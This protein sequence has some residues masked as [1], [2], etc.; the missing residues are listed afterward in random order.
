MKNTLRMLLFTFSLLIVCEILSP[1]EGTL[2]SSND[3]WCQETEANSKTAFVKEDVTKSSLIDEL[4]AKYNRVA[5]SEQILY[6]PVKVQYFNCNNLLNPDCIAYKFG[7]PSIEDVQDEI[8]DTNLNFEYAGYNVRLYL[9]DYVGYVNNDLALNYDDSAKDLEI[10][11]DYASDGVINVFYMK[12][13]DV[14]QH[15]YLP[16]S[17]LDLI[18]L[19]RDFFYYGWSLTHEIGHWFGLHHTFSTEQGVENVTRDSNDP[20]YNCETTGDLL[21]DTP[22]ALNLNF[23]GSAVVNADC[24][25][26]ITA[27]TCNS[28]TY[29]GNPMD[30]CNT[31]IS[32]QMSPVTYLNVMNYGSRNCSQSI[33]QD[34]VDRMWSFIPTRLANDVDL[35]N[36]PP[37][38]YCP[39]ALSL[40]NDNITVGQRIETSGQLQSTQIINTT[41]ATLYDSGTKV[42]LKPGFKA[43]EGAELRVI[44]DGCGNTE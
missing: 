5:M 30:N 37:H 2:Q 11:D 43:G 3:Y 20:C 13:N 8:D 23:F 36:L 19:N 15:A 4:S 39:T 7:I 6:L 33:T 14:S 29:V 41:Q 16:N 22:A 24:N 18:V 12:M 31:P 35:S 40:T 1:W 25:E 9:V 10:Q 32:Y 38:L 34:Q 27:C 28:I 21:C 17:T 44:I 26:D 42:L